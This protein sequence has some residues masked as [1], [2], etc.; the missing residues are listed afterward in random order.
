MQS[1][2]HARATFAWRWL[3]YS[4]TRY[5]S[6]K[7]PRADLVLRVILLALIRDFQG[8]VTPHFIYVGNSGDPQE[9]MMP[10]EPENQNSRFEET[11]L[12][13][14]AVSHGLK[15]FSFLTEVRNSAPARL[16][17]EHRHPSTVGATVGCPD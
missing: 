14:G 9:L 16:Q 4:D 15:A 3:A 8:V 7:C 13:G 12:Q 10:G 17:G 1:R 2:S 5:V 11:S 6:V